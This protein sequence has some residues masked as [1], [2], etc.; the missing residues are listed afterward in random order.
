MTTP[1]HLHGSVAYKGAR[2]PSTMSAD[3][4]QKA[5]FTHYC[6]RCN[7]FW[8]E[9][10]TKPCCRHPLVVPIEW[11]MPRGEHSRSSTLAPVAQSGLHAPDKR[12]NRSHHK[13]E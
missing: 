3:Q 8:R 11:H 4:L 5:G 12:K 7:R 13:K 2:E 1:P 6:S 10:P 9:K